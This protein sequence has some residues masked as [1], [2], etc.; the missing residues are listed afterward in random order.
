MHLFL[1]QRRTG[2][3]CLSVRSLAFSVCCKEKNNTATL[4]SNKIEANFLNS[5]TDLDENVHDVVGILELVEGVLNTM[6]DC[7]E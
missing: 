4:V 5:Q 6:K 2:L 3:T 1:Q 7:E